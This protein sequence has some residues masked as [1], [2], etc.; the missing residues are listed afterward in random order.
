MKSTSTVGFYLRK[1]KINLDKKSQQF[2]FFLMVCDI[3]GKPI[4]QSLNWRITL[5]P[6]NGL[7]WRKPPIRLVYNYEEKAVFLT[8]KDEGQKL[9]VFTNRVTNSLTCLFL[10][11][12]KSWF[13]NEERWRTI[14]IS[15]FNSYFGNEALTKTCEPKNDLLMDFSN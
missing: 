7:F 6:S 10:I 13:F 1:I 11:W 15:L 5:P 14:L 3:S 8:G 12:R 9:T 4:I 2:H